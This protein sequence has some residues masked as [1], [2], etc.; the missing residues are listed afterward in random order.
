MAFKAMWAENSPYSKLL[1]SVGII[2]L[3]AVFFTFISTFLISSLQGVDMAQLQLII[4]DLG[5]ERGITILKWI[6]AFSSIGT[7]IVPPLLLAYFFRGDISAY[8]SLS[9]KTDVYSLVLVFLLLLLA[10]PL[11]NF[12]GEMNNSFHLPSFLEPVEKWMRESEDRAALLT[13]AF[14]KMDNLNSLLINLLII[15]VI[16]AIGEEL[17]FRGLVQRIFTDWSKNV[18][19]GVWL[20]ALL[21]SA[22]HMQFYGFI[23]RVLLGA[24]LG[25]L[26]V[27][28]G[29][30]W[31]PILAHFIN[32]AAAVL[33]TYLYRHQMMSL[34]PDE[35]GTVSSDQMPVL[36][37]L[38]TTI[39]LIF[40]LHRH[41]AKKRL[42][43]AQ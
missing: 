31:L 19:T 27:W 24:L 3:S 36:F 21:F 20:A 32:N 11:I 7:F 26:L 42:L 28:S 43:S 23:P 34:N 12:L 14:L 16:P 41:Q 17:L 18:H 30:L 6:H 1:L 5:N 22:M 13:E 15:A 40:V 39:A 29:S 2:L 9:K 37:S 8:L 35:I 33:F 10:L 25:Y 4:S 38:V